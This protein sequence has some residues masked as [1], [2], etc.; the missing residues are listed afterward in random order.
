MKIKI[1]YLKNKINN[2]VKIFDLRNVKFYLK[3]EVSTNKHRNK[4]C[5][6]QVKYINE[7]LVKFETYNNKLILLLLIKNKIKEIIK[8]S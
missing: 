1:I 7:L 8:T 3:I 4:S 2:K 5:L 6:S